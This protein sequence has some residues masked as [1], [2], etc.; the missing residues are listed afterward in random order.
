MKK[1]NKPKS[2]KFREEMKQKN[3]F[4]RKSLQ[5]VLDFRELMHLFSLKINTKFMEKN[6]KM[7]MFKKNFNNFDESSLF[8][9]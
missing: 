5:Y 8:L 3:C 4:F 1:I 2:H 7:K 6:I 9:E